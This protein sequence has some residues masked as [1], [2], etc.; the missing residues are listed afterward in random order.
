MGSYTWNA[1][2]T[3]TGCICLF[4]QERAEF[5]K[6]QAQG[7]AARLEAEHAAAQRLVEEAAA[8]RS[9]ARGVGVAGSRV[10]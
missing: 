2:S 7:D 3:L 6:S 1:G 9:V 10:S 4:A 5:L 8:A